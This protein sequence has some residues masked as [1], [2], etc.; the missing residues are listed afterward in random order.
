M[1]EIFV[2]RT[3]IIQHISLLLYLLTQRF[4]VIHVFQTL[5]TK[6]STQ[7]SHVSYMVVVF[8]NFIVRS[9]TLIEICCH[10]QAY[11]S[12]LTCA[13]HICIRNCTSVCAIFCVRCN[14]ILQ[15]LLLCLRFIVKSGT[16]RLRH[17]IETL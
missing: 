14:H 2:R 16:L 6:I 15:V 4:I 8:I 17:P 11:I 3:T 9:L 7:Y 12:D 1:P 10:K 13:L 5:L